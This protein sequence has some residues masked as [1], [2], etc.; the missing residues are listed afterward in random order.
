MTT[1]SIF[2][3]G[4]VGCVSAAC[5]ASRGHSVIGVDA[6]PEKMALLGAGRAPV[7]EERIGELTAEVVASGH[8][9]VNADP[10]A[11]VLGSDITIVCV[12]TPSAPNGSL[13][14]AFLERA[15]EQIGAA[16]ALKDSWHVVV[17]RSTMIPGTCEGVLT[18]ILERTS[19]KVAGADFG[20]CVNPEFLREGTS[21]RD[22]LDPPKTVIGQVGERGGEEVMALYEGL[23]GPRFQVPVRVAEMTKYVD[24]SFHALKVGY[25]NEIGAI[26]SALDL[27]SHAVM[28]IFTAD[29]K[30]NISA[31]YL[32]PGFA[33]GGSCLPKDLR[34][35]THAARRNDV[36]I[37]V[38][39]NLL[40]SN[41][42][43]VRRVVDLVASLGRRRVGVFGLSFKAGTDDLR[44][45]PMVELT[46]RLIGKGYDV[47]VYDDNVALSRLVG[48]NRAYIEE[49]LPHIG[50]I[51]TGDI[52]EVVA[53]GEIFIVG[54]TK[55]AVAEAVD[56]L[57]EDCSVIDLVRLPE[58]HRLRARPGYHGI[59]W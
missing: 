26:C 33:F 35:L 48:A 17:Y 36:D 14:T 34:A 13:S 31:A 22:F 27:D 2:G 57:N 53:H 30:L 44:E 6:N 15:T 21:V 47:R 55:P 24:N 49:R 52:D 45:S 41:E 9:T 7:V 42:T 19:G 20:V 37:P 1:L 51:L 18:P 8:L 5:F 38:L 32:R 11:A 46:E 58:A 3:L 54:S 29:T 25:A 12:G 28:D 43:H 23:P 4:Y 56:T 10:T 40:V 59:A 50:E 39:S 16:L